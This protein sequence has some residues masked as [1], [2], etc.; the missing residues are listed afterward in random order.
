M[1]LVAYDQLRF[2]KTKQTIPLSPKIKEERPCSTN[3]NDGQKRKLSF[4]EKFNWCFNYSW[5][6]Q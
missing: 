4:F 6:V 1:S 3:F 2:K 5:W